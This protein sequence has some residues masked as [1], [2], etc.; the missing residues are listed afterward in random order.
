[1]DITFEQAIKGFRLYNEAA[2]RAKST[3]S[4]A[5]SLTCAM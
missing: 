3:Y 1:M 5:M 2:G 4:T